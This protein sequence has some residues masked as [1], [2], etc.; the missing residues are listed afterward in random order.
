MMYNKENEVM[1]MGKHLSPLEKEFLIKRYLSNPRVKLNDFCIANDISNTAFKKWLDIYKM[2]GIEG[3]SK[4]DKG[5][6]VLPDGVEQ[7]TENLKREI[8]KLRI[9]NERFKKN[10]TVQENPDGT[11]TY[12]RLKEKSS[13]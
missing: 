13:Q 8:I 1:N 3:L 6:P 7:T 4:G 11:I 10:Y 5:Y 2:E 12:I 9:E